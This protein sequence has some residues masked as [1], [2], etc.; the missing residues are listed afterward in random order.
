ML[1]VNLATAGQ[2]LDTLEPHGTFCFQTFDDT[3]H[4][5]SALV[6]QLHGK[7]E[8]V[9]FDL[10]TANEEGG[11]VFVTI[12]TTDGT[13]RKTG[14]ITKVRACFIDQDAGQIPTAW[15]IPPTMVVSRDPTHWHAYWVLTD[16]GLDAFSTPRLTREKLRIS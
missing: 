11:G 16:C 14:N 15:H 10:V 6:K 4:K 7:L 12:N 9:G 3:R 2:Y 5:R 1:Q 8:D 13:G